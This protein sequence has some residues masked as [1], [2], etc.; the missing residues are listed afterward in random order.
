MGIGGLRVNSQQR[1]VDRKY[2]EKEPT[3]EKRRR[4]PASRQRTVCGTTVTENPVPWSALEEISKLFY[5]KLNLSL[6]MF[7]M[8]RK[9]GSPHLK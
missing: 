8:D 9:L 3:K 4:G 6:L 5:K 1:K 2:G 7:H